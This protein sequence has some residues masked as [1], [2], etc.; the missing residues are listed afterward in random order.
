MASGVREATDDQ[1]E[2]LLCSRWQPRQL[3]SLGLWATSGILDSSFVDS[4]LVDLSFVD[5]S[6]ADSSFVDSSFVDSSLADWSFADSS[7]A[8]YHSQYVGEHC[9]RSMVSQVSELLCSGVL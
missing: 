9:E 1:L 7:C 2:K 3:R 6:F 4:S 5:W 8:R